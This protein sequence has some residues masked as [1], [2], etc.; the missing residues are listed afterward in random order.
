MK[1]QTIPT[2]RRDKVSL[3]QRVRYF[4]LFFNRRDWAKCHGYLDPKL[5]AKYAEA[6]YARMMDGFFAAHGPLRQMTV[7]SANLY[8]A[9]SA[10]AD[11]REFA[12]VVLS[13]KDRGNARYHFRERWIKEGGRWF[14]RV[15]GLVPRPPGE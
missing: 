15:V 7:V 9:G 3:L 4:Y 8:S 14:T 13:W 2:P 11:D 6:D 10:R 5:R 12:Y 1:T